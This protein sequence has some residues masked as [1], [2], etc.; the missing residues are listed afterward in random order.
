MTKRLPRD[1]VGNDS[2]NQ[3]EQYPFP[4]TG[5][6]RRGLTNHKERLLEEAR[7]EGAQYDTPKRAERR[8]WI[9]LFV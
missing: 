6:E 3:H 4:A 2:I 9:F 5:A 8:Q 7:F 1:D